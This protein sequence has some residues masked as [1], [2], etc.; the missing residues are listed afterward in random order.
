MSARDGFDP[1]ATEGGSHA[2]RDIITLTALHAAIR[3]GM[4]GAAQAMASERVAHKPESPW[5]RN[6]AMRADAIAQKQA[7]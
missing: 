7:A 3:G 6:L 4:A 5:A 1:F 2:Q